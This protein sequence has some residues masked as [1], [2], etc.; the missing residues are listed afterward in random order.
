MA[1]E[2]ATIFLRS[3]FNIQYKKG[4][5]DLEDLATSRLQVSI[6]DS[7]ECCVRYIDRKTNVW[8]MLQISRLF[9]SRGSAIRTK[10][11]SETL[12][13]GEKECGKLFPS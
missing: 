10:F 8:K 4:F 6:R 1:H 5:L 3:V 9:C 2:K 13:L 7:V 11:E 12:I